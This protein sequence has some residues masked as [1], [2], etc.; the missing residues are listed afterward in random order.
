M[1]TVLHSVFGVGGMLLM[2]KR[3]KLENTWDKPSYAGHSFSSTAKFCL[4][5]ETSNG[6]MIRSLCNIVQSP[7]IVGV[8]L[9]LGLCIEYHSSGLCVCHKALSELQYS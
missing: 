3:F 4:I 5:N 9:E 6:V 1:L 2:L 8:L 7:T